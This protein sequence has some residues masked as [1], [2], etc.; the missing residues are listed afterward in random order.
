[1]HEPCLDPNW[2]NSTVKGIFKQLVKFEYGLDIRY[3]E[4]LLLILKNKLSSH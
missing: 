3:K 1:M 4:L 2:N